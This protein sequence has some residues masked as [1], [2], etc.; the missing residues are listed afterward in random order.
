VHSLEHDAAAAKARQAAAATQL[1]E[2]ERLL[3]QTEAERRD[4]R[5]KYVALS[6]KFESVQGLESAARH[7]AQVGEPSFCY[8]SNC[9]QSLLHLQVIHDWVARG[10][11]CKVCPASAHTPPVLACAN[12]QADEAC[13]A[14][15]TQGRIMGAGC[16]TSEMS[17][18]ET[19]QA[20]TSQ[21]C[22]GYK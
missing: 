14:M 11:V 12:W 16:D 6:R 21:R 18:R 10:T 13:N 2:L 4:A 22:I 5:E 9:C 3:A 1:R 8:Q 7:G 17:F 19:S 20:I 15:P